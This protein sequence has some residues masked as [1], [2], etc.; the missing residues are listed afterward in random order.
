MQGKACM[1]ACPSQS[2]FFFE[3]IRMTLWAII[4]NL[5]HDNTPASFANVLAFT[6][7]VNQPRIAFRTSRTI[8]NARHTLFAT[9]SSIRLN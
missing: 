6:L 2:T 4:I 7:V 9:P 5:I 1:A 8:V 3:I